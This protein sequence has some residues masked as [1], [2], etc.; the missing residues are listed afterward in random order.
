MGG[1]HTVS[2][3]LCNKNILYKEE[4]NV[5]KSQKNNIFIIYIDIF[6]RCCRS[7]PQIQTRSA[8]QHAARKTKSLRM[9]NS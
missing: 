4:Q 8:L 6:N 7:S 9:K 2:Y 5:S 3:I 1:F